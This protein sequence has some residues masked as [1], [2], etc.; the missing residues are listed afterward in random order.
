MGSKTYDFDA[1]LQFKDS[2]LVAATAAAQVGGSNKVIDVGQARVEMAV[3]IDVTAVE[4]ASNDEEYDI[5]VQ[6]S[7]DSSFTAG[8]IENLAHL[9]LGAQEVRQGLSA[10]T[11]KDSATG[12]YELMFTNEQDDTIY[13]YLRMITVVAGSIASGI[14]YKAFGA[15]LPGK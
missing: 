11:V 9:N 1:D 3:I 8:T 7:T 13:R 2:G 6:G 4:I 12:R 5:I 15:K 14:N 10:S